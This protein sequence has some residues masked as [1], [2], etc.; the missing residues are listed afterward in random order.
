M[1]RSHL[2][3]DKLCVFVVLACSLGLMAPGCR[4][5]DEDQSDCPQELTITYTLNLITNLTIELDEKL[6]SDRDIPLRRAIEDYLKDIFVKTARDVDLSF[7]AVDNEGAR[8]VHRAEMMNAEQATYVISIPA[9]DYKHLGIANLMG[10]R[11]VDLIDE[12]F[13]H[14]SALDQKSAHRV[15]P[16]NTGLFTA[17]KD[18]NVLQ[19]VDQS[20]EV[21][22]YMAND[23]TAFIIHRDSCDYRKISMEIEGLANTFYVRDSVYNYDFHTFLTTDF[24][25]A[26]PFVSSS[27]TA[28]AQLDWRT[29][30]V[31]KAGSYVHDPSY[32]TWTLVPGILIG[33][34]FPSKDEGQGKKIEGVD[35]PVLWIAH[36][37]VTLLDGTITKSTIYIG[38]RLPA[39]NLLIFRGWLKGDG[40]YVP[41]PPGGGGDSKV[42]GV[43][44]TLD[45]QE[46]LHFEPEL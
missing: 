16:H 46:G 3:L 13:S 38:E 44:V 43:S 34:G 42:V 41:G 35:D 2:L 19:G 6:S 39:G 10:E 21:N 31:T 45:W 8:K 15:A 22:L 1:R 5:I 11:S 27:S 40:S 14:S 32:D 37:Y 12:E 17:R 24:I 26:T 25:D 23:A 28:G 4:L 36:L 30:P 33:V 9:D 29:S 7:Y 20:F 18:M